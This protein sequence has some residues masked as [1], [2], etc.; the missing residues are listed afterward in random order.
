[1]GSSRYACKREFEDFLPAICTVWRAK[2]FIRD[3]V[4]HKV[5]GNDYLQLYWSSGRS[6]ALRPFSSSSHYTNYSTPKT[7]DVVNESVET[8]NY[9]VQRVDPSYVFTDQ[10]PWVGFASITLSFRLR[11]FNCR[12]N[13]SPYQ[14]YNGPFRSFLRS[15]TL[16]MTTNVAYT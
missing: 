15:C 16:S 5:E 10:S 14:S 2:N 3:V 1:M 11:T 4:L 13:M 8:H 9:I 12:A 7:L 6:T